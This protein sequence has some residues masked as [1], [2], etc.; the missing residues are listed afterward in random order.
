MQMLLLACIKPRIKTALKRFSHRRHLWHIDKIYLENRPQTLGR[1]SGRT[2]S[3]RIPSAAEQVG[4]KIKKRCMLL[5]FFHKKNAGIG[6]EASNTDM[7][8]V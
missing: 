3:M 4:R 1:R 2:C 6:N 8:L 5:Y 7:N